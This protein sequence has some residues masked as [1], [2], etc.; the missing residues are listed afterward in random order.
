[1]PNNKNK[2]RD[3]QLKQALQVGPS[4]ASPGLAKWAEKPLT[5]A[6]T[7][8][9]TWL[10]EKLYGR[11]D[12]EDKPLE[13]SIKGFNRGALE[14][15]GNLLS[16]STTPAEAVIPFPPGKRV[17]HGSGKIFDK[18][19]LRKVDKK[20]LL[21]DPSAMH[22]AE[23]PE[24]ARGYAR[25][26]FH[27]TGVIEPNIRSSSLDV[28]RALDLYNLDE[29]DIEILSK[30]FS[31]GDLQALLDINPSSRATYLSELLRRKG[32][33]FPE[34]TGYQAIRY[35]DYQQPTWALYDPSREILDSL[36]TP[37]TVKYL[38]PELRIQPEDLL[39][40]SR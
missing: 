30:V 20:D 19:D 40:R 12:L 3:H 2:N 24:Y 11:N 32:L 21:S 13:A 36:I 16:E 4:P 35:T 7:R 34:K 18:F 22:F 33:N 14:A 17:F 31:E 1:M 9:L 23:N 37:S 38:P 29:E 39:R 28:D 8:L 15:I 10:G 5:D 25:E 6:P 26:R 27:D